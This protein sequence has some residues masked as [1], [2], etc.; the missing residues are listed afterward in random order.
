MDLFQVFAKAF[1]SHI[2]VVTWKLTAACWTIFF[3]CRF[4]HFLVF[5]L[6]I[7]VGKQLSMSTLIDAACFSNIH[8]FIIIYYYNLFFKKVFWLLLWCFLGKTILTRLL[9]TCMRWTEVTPRLFC[10]LYMAHFIV[11][12]R[13]II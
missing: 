9:E 11:I 6:K 12:V 13:I 10:F 8:F 4:V 5:F 1:C 7:S 2:V 3:M